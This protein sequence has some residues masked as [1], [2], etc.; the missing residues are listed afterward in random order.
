M[1]SKTTISIFVL[2]QLLTAAYSQNDSTSL[3]I[4]YEKEVIYFSG[5]RYI[6]NNISYPL[7]NL[8][9]EFKTNTEGYELYK[10][11]RSDLRKARIYAIVGL[12]SLI[13]GFVIS[14]TNN[15]IGATV[16]LA[17]FIPVGISMSFSVKADKKM[18]KAVWLR[19]RDVLLQKY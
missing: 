7:K 13:S 2:L 14:N 11:Y 19:N 4:L 10:L 12:G 1:F 17:S 6:K 8:G 16:A 9:T 15:N 3:K 18:R 5:A